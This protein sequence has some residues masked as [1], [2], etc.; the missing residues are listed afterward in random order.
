MG[1]GELLWIHKLSFI[2]MFSCL[3]SSRYMM[4]IEGEDK[5]FMLDRNNSVFRING[6]RFPNG[7]PV[8]DHLTN[9]L[10]DGV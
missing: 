1:Q 5:I 9:T 2:F 8:I 7:V 10:L 3:C 6:L 4:F